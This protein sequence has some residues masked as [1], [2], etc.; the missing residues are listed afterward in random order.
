[1][2]GSV[3]LQVSCLGF[4]GVDSL[5]DTG[6]LEGL[7]C[8]GLAERLEAARYQGPWITCLLRRRKFRWDSTEDVL[9]D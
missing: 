3:N 9:P 2:S 6:C 7:A 5:V 1:M 8:P 4:T